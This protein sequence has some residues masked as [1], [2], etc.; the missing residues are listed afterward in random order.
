MRAKKQGVKIGLEVHCQLTNLE[1]KLFCGCPSDYRGAGPNSHVCPVCFGLPGALPVLNAEAVKDAV[2]V[3][4]ALSSKIPRKTIFFR[5]NYYYPDMSKNFQ[6]SQYDKA[7]GIPIAIGGSLKIG[8]DH[9]QKRIGITRMQLEEDPAKLVHLGT[10]KTSPY[11]LVDYNRSGIALLE[12]VTEPD[13]KSPAES[14]VFLKKLRSI[15]EHLGVSN[16]ELEGAMRCDANISLRGGGRVEIKNISSFKE[17]ERA[18]RFEIM[19][20]TSKTERGGKV[21]TETRHWD[22]ARRVTMSLRTKETEEEYRYFPEPDLVPVT[23]SQDYIERCKSALPELPDVRAKRFVE[24]Y[25][26]P[27]YDA[28]VLTS[29]KALAD[30][31]ENCVRI[32]HDPKKISNW[33]MG[34]LLRRLHEEDVEVQESK[35][36][37]ENLVKMLKLEDEGIISGKIAKKVLL[38]MVKTGD[39]PARIVE[40]EGLQRIFSEEILEEKVEKVFELNPKAVKDAIRDEKAAHFLVGELM[41]LTNGKADPQLANKI[42]KRKLRKTS[43]K[44]T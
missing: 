35:I 12:I 3:A 6:I 10:I 24:E 9:K 42:V 21:E 44:N 14:R 20:Q 19:R 41:K 38:L 34:D 7:G 18:L 5:K 17:V 32:Y 15:L 2:M 27:I 1:T 40:K 26:L 23:I 13:L 37:P 8:I 22:E 39:T 29:E 36:T 30:F 11:T 25:K 16:G 33:I 4:L 28:G 43:K 31:F